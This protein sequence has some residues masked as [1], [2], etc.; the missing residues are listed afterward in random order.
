MRRELT[1]ALLLIVVPMTMGCSMVDS[2][3][4]VRFESD[5]INLHPFPYKIVEGTLENGDTQYEM[6]LP[7]GT[8]QTVQGMPNIGNLYLIVNLNDG[9]S[10]TSRGQVQA[11]VSPTVTGQGNATGGADSS[12][13]ELVGD[14]VPEGGGE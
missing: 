14:T 2:E 9:T 13:T 12:S 8:Y 10:Q 6:V 3:K 5:S 7:D 4:L 11:E 1:L